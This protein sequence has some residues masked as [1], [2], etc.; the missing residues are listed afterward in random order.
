MITVSSTD[1]WSFADESFMVIFMCTRRRSSE[2][3]CKF[4]WL[5]YLIG[6]AIITHY[7]ARI[8]P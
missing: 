6:S 3:K 2:I 4:G 7:L 1:D 5:D 8:S